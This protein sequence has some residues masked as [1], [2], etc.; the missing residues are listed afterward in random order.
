[1]RTVVSRVWSCLAA[2]SALL[3]LSACTSAGVAAS[4]IAQSS[5]T[6][7]GGVTVPPF[8]RL[9][10]VTADVQN[11]PAPQ[12]PDEIVAMTEDFLLGGDEPI[13]VSAAATP[14]MIDAKLVPIPSQGTASGNANRASKNVKRIVQAMQS[15][16]A[17]DGL[18]TWDGILLAADYLSEASSPLIVVVSSGLDTSGSMTTTQGL[19]TLTSEQVADHVRQENPDLDLSGLSVVLVSFGYTATPQT[20]MSPA[21]RQVVTSAWQGALEAFGASVAVVAAPNTSDSV[22]SAY[23]VATTDVNQTCVVSADGIQYTF[24][25]STLPFASDSAALPSN[26]GDALAP[27]VSV[28]RSAS[29]ATVDVIGNTDAV[30]SPEDNLTLGRDRAEAVASY[31]RSV[32]S[33]ETVQIQTSSNGE[34]SPRVREDGLSGGDLESARALNRRVEIS[35]KGAT[36]SCT[37]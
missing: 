23:P 25:S 8:D 18:S 15:P 14:T 3:L 27:V 11:V 9:A 34:S 36:T 1:M 24:D 16:A 35:V 28:L 29:N 32:G 22:N 21:Q 7:L 30:G 19:L 37:N 10:F 5:S 13:L 26:A 33:A 31:L 17:S 12:L 6:T 4:D 2:G 20:P